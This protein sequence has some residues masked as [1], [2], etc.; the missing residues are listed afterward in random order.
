MCLILC[1]LAIRTYQAYTKM[2]EQSRQQAAVR[3]VGP[4]DEEVAGGT[5]D[6]LSF[7]GYNSEQREDLKTSVVSN[8]VS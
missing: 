5:A 2:R 3:S 1:Q 8:E 7:G 6:V 4:V